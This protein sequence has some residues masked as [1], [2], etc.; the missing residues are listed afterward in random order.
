[1]IDPGQLRCS[2]IITQKSSAVNEYN[3]STGQFDAVLQ[4]WSKIAPLTSKEVYAL[5]S[6][7]SEQATHKV[8]I[9]YRDGIKAGMQIAYRAQ[10]YRIQLVSDPDMTRAQLDLI[11]LENPQ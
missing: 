2:I 1:M 3:E 6:G 9:R 11:C 5:G 7:F 8:T 4:T 10:T